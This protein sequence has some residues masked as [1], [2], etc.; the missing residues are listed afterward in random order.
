[1]ILL[2]IFFISV[3]QLI[4]IQIAR[5]SINCRVFICTIHML[6]KISCLCQSSTLGIGKLICFVCFI[7][8]LIRSY[9]DRDRYCPLR[10]VRLSSSF[11]M[12]N[13]SLRVRR[14][15]RRTTLSRSTYVKKKQK[16]I[17]FLIFS[18][19]SLLYHKERFP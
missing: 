7:C 19:S 13:P 1:M 18:S 16:R 9:I 17:Y 5:F 3:C 11:S 12:L 14:T 6:Y 15:K 2:L 10:V 4:S 8:T